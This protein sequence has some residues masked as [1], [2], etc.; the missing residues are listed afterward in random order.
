MDEVGVSLAGIREVVVAAREALAGLAEVLFQADGAGLREVLGEVDALVA[1]GAAARVQV[2]V[3]AARRGEIESSSAASRVAW[4]R[5]YAPSLRQGGAGAVAAL[6]VQ[7]AD[8]GSGLSGEVGPEGP[9]GAVWRRVAAGECEVGLGLDVLRELARLRPHLAPEAVGTVTEALLDLG[10]SWGAAQMRQLRPALLARYGVEGEFDD[11]QERLASSASLSRPRVASGALTDYR[12]ALTP[13]QAAVLEAAIGPG[14]RPRVGEEGQ[15]DERP[16]GQRRVEALIE[17]VAAWA[18]DVAGRTHGPGGSSVMLHVTMPLQ[19]LTAGMGSGEV[20]GGLAAGTL[21]APGLVRRLA[22]QAGV[23]P[24]VL[25]SRS[26]PLDVGRAERLFTSAQRHALGLRDR[27]CTYPGCEVPA[28]WCRAH[29]VIHWLDGGRTDLANA[30]L[31]CE[32]HHGLVHARRLVAAVGEVPDGDGRFV[33]WRL[34]PGSYDAVLQAEHGGYCRGP[35]CR[36]GPHAPPR[37][38]LTGLH[39]LVATMLANDA[40]PGGR[41]GKPRAE[42]EEPLAE[43]GDLSCER[44]Q[45]TAGREEPTAERA[46]CV[47]DGDAA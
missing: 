28:H 44:D 47:D 4:V 22:C 20:V 7:V 9:L 1:M 15:R 8:T 25:G 16:A 36:H 18:A 38:D 41:S 26:E 11:L 17:V 2:V 34:R 21:L 42:R 13:E 10:V 46:V 29:H 19:E 40:D 39:R 37:L 32:R 35:G 5:E 12:M 31:L 14:S 23:V 3:E 43:R 45:P 33:V 30:A 24:H 6:A 27:H